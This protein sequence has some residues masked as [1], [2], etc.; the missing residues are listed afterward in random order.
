MLQVDANAGPRLKTSTH[1]IDQ[2]IRGLEMRGC[3]GVARFPSVETGNRVRLFSCP[4]DF[5]QRPARHAAP[6]R[7]DARSLAGLFLI[8][9]RPRRV[10]KTLGRLLCRKLQKTI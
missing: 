5:D 4:S 6:R 10:P 9:W 7:R 2:D 3:V 1:R 8:V